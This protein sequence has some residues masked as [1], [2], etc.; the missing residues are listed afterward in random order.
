[1]RVCL[2]LCIHVEDK[3]WPRRFDY[4]LARSIRR[5]CIMLQARRTGEGSVQFFFFFPD[6][7]VNPHSCCLFSF[8]AH[9]CQWMDGLRARQILAAACFVLFLPDSFIPFFFL[10]LRNSSTFVV[11]TGHD[12]Y[13]SSRRPISSSCWTLVSKHSEKLS[14]LCTC[15]GAFWIRYLVVLQSTSPG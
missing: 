2:C 4:S 7:S 10:L 12:C 9:R 1:M 6:F 13:L 14:T 5:T 8:F 11:F 3:R 15:D